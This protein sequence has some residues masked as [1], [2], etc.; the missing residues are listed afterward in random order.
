[1]SAEPREK[2]SVLRSLLVSDKCCRIHWKD[3]QLVKI[4]LEA[5]VVDYSV[6]F[7]DLTR[8][9]LEVVGTIAAAA[10]SSY[11][12][13]ETGCSFEVDMHHSETFASGEVTAGDSFPAAPVAVVLTAF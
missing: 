11:G 7:L 9:T 1:M 3:F 6:S 5:E 8:L 10:Q 13:R 2:S 4:A 12:A